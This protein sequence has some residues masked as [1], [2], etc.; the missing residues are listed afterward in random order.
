MVTEFRAALA[1]RF[2]A[3]ASKVYPG[4]MSTEDPDRARLEKQWRERLAEESDQELLASLN[5]EVGNPGWVSVRGIYLMVLRRELSKRGWDLSS[6]DGLA[7][8]PGGRRFSLEGERLVYAE[9][10]RTGAPGGAV[11]FLWPDGTGRPEPPPPASPT[12]PGPQEVRAAA[13]CLGVNADEYAAHLSVLSPD[14]AAAEVAAVLGRV[15]PGTVEG[16]V[17][18]AETEDGSLVFVPE[19]RARVL[20]EVVDAWWASG[21]W[22]ELRERLERAGVADE[23]LVPFDY[24]DGYQADDEEID[25]GQKEESTGDGDWPGWPGAEQLNW[26]PQDVIDMGDTGVSM[27]SGPA[28]WF[29]PDQEA[30]LVAAL[31]QRGFR[32]RRDDAL[33]GMASAVGR[34]GWEHARRQYNPD[35]PLR[36]PDGGPWGDQ[37]P[38]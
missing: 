7:V 37:E 13:E 19:A 4:G 34:S 18:Y 9:P 15:D 2:V 22:G 5:R 38:G 20:A 21:T 36:L 32:C 35:S 1:H 33:V 14:Q 30:R 17:V 27:V 8:F 10:A 26:M 16:D 25:E 24:P 11:V 28:V 31:V 29:E 23:F 12:C 3:S 6:V